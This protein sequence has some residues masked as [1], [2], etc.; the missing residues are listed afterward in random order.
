M[1]AGFN[2]QAGVREQDIPKI[3]A[4]CRKLLRPK[5]ENVTRSLRAGHH[6]PDFRTVTRLQSFERLLTQNRISGSRE[7]HQDFNLIF[8]RQRQVSRCTV[9]TDHFRYLAGTN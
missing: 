4:A 2:G 3:F 1:N 6:P 7:K 9:A 8:R 5:M